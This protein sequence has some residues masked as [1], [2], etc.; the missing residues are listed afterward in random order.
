MPMP[1]TERQKTE[2]LLREQLARIEK[3][4]FGG[5]SPHVVF[6]PAPAG[7][8]SS[9]GWP[10]SRLTVTRWPRQAREFLRELFSKPRSLQRIETWTAAA[11]RRLTS[12]RLPGRKPDRLAELQ[13]ELDGL[14]RELP[15][16]AAPATAGKPAFGG[17]ARPARPAFVAAM[18]TDVGARSRDLP[19]GSDSGSR[20]VAMKDAPAR[21]WGPP[22]AVQFPRPEKKK[23]RRGDLVIAALG[24]VLGLTCA[25]FP[26]YIFF[27][28][29]QF[30]VQAIALGGKGHNAGRIMIDPRIGNDLADAAA[31]DMKKNLDLFS[32]GTVPTK[33]ETPENAP[34][35]EDQPFPSEAAEFRLVH[36]ANGRAMIED[37]AGLWVVQQGS[38]LPDSTR[39]KS[40]EKRNGRWVLVTSADRV[41]E[42]SK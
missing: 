35:L 6:A 19:N 40:I 14:R 29:E 21:N 27:N 18:A 37:N 2:R 3:A 23:D 5:R 22:P 10:A 34:G 11:Y 25:L 7:T 16:D 28:Q 30:G 33:P 4:K 32:T 12:L 17:A 20:F 42:L 36:V 31:Q 15:H 1:E 13:A 38:T 9:D 24:V 8:A 41:V 26:W 39:V